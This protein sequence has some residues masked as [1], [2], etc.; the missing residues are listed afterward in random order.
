MCYFV[1]KCPRS[2]TF[3][4]DGGLVWYDSF[5]Y[6]EGTQRHVTRTN[7]LLFYSATHDDTLYLCP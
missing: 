7:I 6:I 2:V 5:V 4:C 3:A 1:E